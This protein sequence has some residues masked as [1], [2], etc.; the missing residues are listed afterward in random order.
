[1]KRYLQMLRNSNFL[2]PASA[3]DGNVSA[4]P[5]AAVFQPSVVRRTSDVASATL[6]RLDLAGIEE[7]ARAARSAWIAG[8]LEFYYAALVRKF[9][10]AGKSELENYLAESRD[11]ADVEERLRRYERRHLPYY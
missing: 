8:R 7:Q 11:L 10:R 3:C 2:Q 1:M 6:P 5:D 9:K 4:A